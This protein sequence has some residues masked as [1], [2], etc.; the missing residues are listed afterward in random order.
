M[1]EDFHFHVHA[2]HGIV[3]HVLLGIAWYGAFCFS[4][5]AIGVVGVLVA[6]SAFEFLFSTVL[7][8]RS[9]FFYTVFLF[10]D[11]GLWSALACLS[12]DLAPAYIAASYARQWRV[13]S[14]VDSVVFFVYPFTAL[15]AFVACSFT[16][17]F[18]LAVTS[19]TLHMPPAASPMDRFRS[20]PLAAAV[21]LPLTF[22]LLTLPFSWFYWVTGAHLW[23]LLKHSGWLIMVSVATCASVL[24]VRALAGAFVAW[25]DNHDEVGW[26]HAQILGPPRLVASARGA[27]PKEV[28]DLVDW[29]EDNVGDQRR[30]S[31]SYADLHYS[32]THTVH[33]TRR[34]VRQIGVFGT[35]VL[36]ERKML[37][38]PEM[39]HDV[40]ATE[41]CTANLQVILM[42]CAHWG[43]GSTPLH[44]NE[45]VT[46]DTA[47]YIHDRLRKMSLDRATFQTSTDDV[48]PL[49][50]GTYQLGTVP[51]FQ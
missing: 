36:N 41:L 20:S 5:L 38:C 23:A 17:S 27:P 22:L 12:I 2:Q 13:K 39:V 11:V 43:A 25:Y 47:E 16:V 28:R 44:N 26:T 1:L 21:S 51:S 30:S 37:I 31:A 48:G 35:M 34:E 3:G 10:L 40:L 29:V 42:R 15:A 18:R 7:F 45:V 33:M 14:L 8:W 49:G 6:L 46:S 9:G 50:S 24:I 19:I 4:V 32:S